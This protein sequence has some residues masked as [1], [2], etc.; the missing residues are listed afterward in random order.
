ML[1]EKLEEYN[2][3]FEK[4]M[5][6]LE[7]P[8]MPEDPKSSAPSTTDETPKKSSFDNVFSKIDDTRAVDWLDF[9]LYIALLFVVP[10]LPNR[11]VKTAVLSL[12]KGCALALQWT[13]TLELLDKMDVHF[14]HWHH[15]LLQQVQNK[16]ISLSVFR[17]VQHYLVHILFIVKQL[18]L[19]RYYSTWSMERVIGVF[20]KLIKSK[21]KGSRN[22]SFLVERFALHNYINTAIRIQNEIDLIQLKPY[23]R[24]S[25][26]D[27]PNDP[28]EGVS[29]PSVKD[30]LTR[31]YQQTLGL[32]ISDIDDSTIVVAGRLWM[33][34]TI[35]SSCMY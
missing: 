11:A 20:F 16:T 7:E 35:H 32:M 6:E 21:C 3:A 18:S 9:L 17:P 25:Y 4:I 13:L 33:N 19:L 8:E 31:Y 34:L 15:Y 14:K 5:E 28:S 27:L 10:F 2:S 29:S 26:M 30:A 12:V 22:A 23:G 1:H 24:E